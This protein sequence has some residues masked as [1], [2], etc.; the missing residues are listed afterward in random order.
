M[1]VIGCNLL[2]IATGDVLGQQGLSWQGNLVFSEF[3][4]PFNIVNDISVNARPVNCLSGLHLYLLHP[5]VCAMEVSEG[6]VEEFRGMQTW[7][8]FR[9]ILASRDS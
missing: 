6:M 4:A 1:E 3:V 7:S 2:S 8:P 5:L 9:R